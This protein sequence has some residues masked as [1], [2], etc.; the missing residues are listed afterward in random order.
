KGG[1]RRAGRS[2]GR[3]GH[4]PTVGSVPADAAQLSLLDP[5]DGRPADRGAAPVV[6][7]AGSLTV[8]GVA[9]RT[10]AAVGDDPTE[11]VD[12]VPDSPADHDDDPREEEDE[13][14]APPTVEIRV[15][16]RRR[17]TVD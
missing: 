16:A 3:P 12:A 14:E 15:S 8:A 7:E 2:P 6:E 1:E 11:P 5:P 10:G 17:K 13:Q 9:A 4:R